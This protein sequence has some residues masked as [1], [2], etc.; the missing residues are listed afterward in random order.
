MNQLSDVKNFKLKSHGDGPG[1][2]VVAEAHKDVPFSIARTFFV[3]AAAGQL[4]G[5]HAHKECTQLLVCAS[6]NIEVFLRDGK[7]SKTLVLEQPG[8]SVLIPAGIWAEQKYMTNDSIIIVFCDQPFNES[9][10]IR[11]Y[12]SFEK[13]RRNE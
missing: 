13:F 1:L 3:K 9:D 10:Y 6:G 5:K 4:R 2:L 7:S 11:D 12:Q 8:D